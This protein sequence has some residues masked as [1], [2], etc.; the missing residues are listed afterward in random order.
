MFEKLDKF[1]GNFLAGKGV[2]ICQILMA[3]V[4]IIWGIEGII[5]DIRE[6]VNY[7]QM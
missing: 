7:F 2:I 4:C 6:I 5:K 1:F 3:V